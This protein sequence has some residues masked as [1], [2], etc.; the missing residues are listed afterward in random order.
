MSDNPVDENSEIEIDEIA[1]EMR[2]EIL[3]I[4]DEQNA[5]I[6]S[7]IFSISFWF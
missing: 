3:A 5:I 1:A 2:D 6:A 7:L 4:V